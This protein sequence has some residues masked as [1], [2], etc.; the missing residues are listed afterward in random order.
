MHIDSLCSYFTGN[1]FL[2]VDPNTFLNEGLGQHVRDLFFRELN[3][4]I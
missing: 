2:A 3:G 1:Q 4:T